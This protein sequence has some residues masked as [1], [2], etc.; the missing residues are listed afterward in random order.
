MKHYLTQ[1]DNLALATDICWRNNIRVERI[2]HLAT[3][4]DNE[5]M[6]DVLYYLLPCDTDVAEIFPGFWDHRLPQ[7]RNFCR[8]LHKLDLA[9]CFEQGWKDAKVLTELLTEVGMHGF[10]LQI[11]YPVIEGS[12]SVS[13]LAF[14]YAESYEEALAEAIRWCDDHSPEVRS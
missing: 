2:L 7:V 12:W 13:R 4:P 6:E 8:R 9:G 14:F 11:S 3:L 10:L 5:Y 1:E